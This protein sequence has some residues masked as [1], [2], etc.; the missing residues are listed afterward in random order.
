MKIPIIYFDTATLTARPPPLLRTFLPVTMAAALAS[1]YQVFSGRCSIHCILN[2]YINYDDAQK[3]RI[4][5]NCC[6]QRG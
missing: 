1:R 6:R 2:A 3:C 4:K 5:M